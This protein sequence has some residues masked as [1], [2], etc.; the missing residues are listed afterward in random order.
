MTT[1][2]MTLDYIEQIKTDPQMIEKLTH[3]L[4]MMCVFYAGDDPATSTPLALFERAQFI[5]DFAKKMATFGV[6]IREEQRADDGH[7]L[8]DVL[9]LRSW[10]G[11]PVNH[12]I[13]LGTDGASVGCTQTPMPTEDVMPLPQ[14]MCLF[15]NPDLTARSSC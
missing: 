8:H 9:T 1:N 6:E 2:K 5:G 4:D 13:V 15:C 14:E 12:W 3:A 7:A 10:L 11:L